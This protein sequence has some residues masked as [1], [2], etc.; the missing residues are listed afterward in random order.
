MIFH[1]GNTYFSGLLWS[2][3][4]AYIPCLARLGQVAVNTSY[5]VSYLISFFVSHYQN[6]LI[7]NASLFEVVEY[8]L[9]LSWLN[10][11]DAL[12][13]ADALA[14]IY[15]YHSL[16]HLVAS[17]TISILTLRLE[18]GAINQDGWINKMSSVSF[19]PLYSIILVVNLALWKYMFLIQGGTSFYIWVAQNHLCFVA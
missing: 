8:F 12:E 18:K 15:F 10:A 13:P 9:A 3:R 7:L 16:L 2:F 19:Q 6:V 17:S 4:I 14:H 11:H 1:L 5:I